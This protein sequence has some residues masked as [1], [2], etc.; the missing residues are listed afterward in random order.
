VRIALVYRNVN[1]SGSLERCVALLAAE[2][3]RGGAEVHCY[4]NPDSSVDSIPGVQFHAVRPIATSRG[5]LGYAAEIGSFAVAASRAVAAT[6]IAFDIVN[7]CGPG[8]WIHDVV[9]VHG[10]AQA[11]QRRWPAEGGQS[12]AFAGLRSL[13]APLTAPAFAVGRTIE[14][15]QFRGG[16]FTRAI[17]V[18]ERVAD[19]LIRVH[20]I[21]EDRIDVIPPPVD[22]AR[23]ASRD[24]SHIRSELG[25][26]ANTRLLLFVGHDFE[27]KGLDDAVSSLTGLDET[28][29]LVVVGGADPTA[30]RLL[31]QQLGV[32][33]RVHFVGRTDRP[34]RYFDDADLLVLP[35]KNDPWGMALIEAM[36]AGLPVVTSAVAGA[37]GVVR[38]SGAGIVIDDLSPTVLRA[39]LRS[40]LAAPD[41][42]TECAAA[43]RDAA[44]DYSIE[45]N[46]QATL[47]TYER[48]LQ[49]KRE[50]QPAPQGVATRRV[51]SAEAP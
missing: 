44:R 22:V 23:F 42:M 29:H 17:A 27:R 19:D 11:H 31:A 20:G 18:T 8:G 1:F 14:R 15:L 35:T 4:C 48:V 9:T 13:A 21:P 32:G 6:S 41:R 47:A 39:E 51:R 2:L 45:S 37:S 49:E 33:A 28:A 40:L 16:N 50:L 25:L 26:A 30:H 36:A 3:A 34:E 46:A 10:V 5:R 38:R 7:V 24:R 12:S 43:G